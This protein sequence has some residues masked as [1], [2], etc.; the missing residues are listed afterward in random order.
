M[1]SIGTV[2]RP[3]RVADPDCRQP[4]GN[5]R[6]GH[7]QDS[8]RTDNSAF[9]CSSVRKAAASSGCVA[10]RLASDL[11]SRV[12]GVLQALGWA[13]MPPKACPRVVG[14]PNQ[15]V[16]DSKA[17]KITRDIVE[18]TPRGTMRGRSWSIFHDRTSA[19]EKAVMRVMPF[20]KEDS[21]DWSDDRLLE[22]NTPFPSFR[23]PVH[24]APKRRISGS[25]SDRT[26]R[27]SRE[28]CA[29]LRS[30]K[31]EF[32]DIFSEVT[33]TPILC[34]QRQRHRRTDGDRGP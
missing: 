32:Q 29:V 11:V 22:Q 6:P 23:R 19:H 3:R 8:A 24:A 2:S 21:A 5:R 17:V 14:S 13:S 34:G 9:R 7:P 26:A 10:P 15:R 31:F 18:G 25:P 33:L 20:A 27:K 12:T 4:G 1:T 30:K 28:R 16:A